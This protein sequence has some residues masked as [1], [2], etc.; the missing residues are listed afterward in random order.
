VDK[1]PSLKPSLRGHGSDAVERGRTLFESAAVGCTT[2]HTGRDF[3]NGSSYDI[4]TGGT[5]QVPQLHSLAARAPFMHDGCAATLADRFG[6]KCGGDQRH[7]NTSQLS[8]AEI[9][10]LIAYLETL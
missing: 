9:G 2:C 7:G 1:V 5:F 8:P 3:T 4:G 10:D 6:S